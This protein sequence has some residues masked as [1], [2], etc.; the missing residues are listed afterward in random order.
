M[1]TVKE[2]LKYINDNI[3]PLNTPIGVCIKA[4]TLLKVIEESNTS[5]S[6]EN[7]YPMKDKYADVVLPVYNGEHSPMLFITTDRY[8]E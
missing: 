2:L 5:I 8:E 4:G 1:Y 6:V 3:I 7:Y